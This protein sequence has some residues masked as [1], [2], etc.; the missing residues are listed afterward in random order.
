M[1]LV[2]LIIVLD[3]LSVMKLVWRKNNAST[4]FRGGKMLNVN[5]VLQQLSVAASMSVIRRLHPWM[6]SMDDTSIH[7]WHFS[8]HGWHLSIHG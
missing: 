6:A 2:F 3:G 1:I 5:S 8:I 4:N 7:G